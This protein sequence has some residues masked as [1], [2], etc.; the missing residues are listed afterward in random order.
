MLP[1]TTTTANLLA[2]ARNRSSVVSNQ[3]LLYSNKDLSTALRL[4][5][6]AT[7]LGVDELIQLTVLT[8]PWQ[9]H[10]LS[11]FTCICNL[12]QAVQAG[13]SK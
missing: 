9:L 4:H 10:L 13:H 3:V 8:K 5:A 6:Q 1:K 2:T 12:M 7:L 11:A